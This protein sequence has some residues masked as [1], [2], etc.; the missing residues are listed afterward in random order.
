M[1]H[2]KKI[3]IFQLIDFFDWF[4]IF[5]KII[6]IPGVVN[7]LDPDLDFWPDPDLDFWP[8]PDLMNMDPKHCEKTRQLTMPLREWVPTRCFWTRQGFWAR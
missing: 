2:F 7:R 8:D 4:S 6:F 3:G 1:S 5:K